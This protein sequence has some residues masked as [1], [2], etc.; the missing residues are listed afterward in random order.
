[1]CS[2]AHAQLFRSVKHE[3]AVTPYNRGVDY[4]CRCWNILEL[5]AEKV[6]FKGCVGGLRDKR[7]CMEG[8]YWV[9]G[10]HLDS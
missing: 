6:M 2:E 8:R 1:M 10:S 5:A 7:W 4:D 3:L 9:G